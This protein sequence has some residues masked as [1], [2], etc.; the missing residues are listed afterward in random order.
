MSDEAKYL[1]LGS[2]GM[3][4]ELDIR[5]WFCAVDLEQALDTFRVVEG[6]LQARQEAQPKRKRRSD[7]GTKKVN[8][9][10]EQEHD[11]TYELPDIRS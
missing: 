1:K 3:L 11:G 5:H 7:A 9:R 8:L 6:I 10:E 4:E 2:D